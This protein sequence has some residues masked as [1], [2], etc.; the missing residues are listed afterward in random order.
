MAAGIVLSALFY[1]KSSID[2]KRNMRA[3]LRQKR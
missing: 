1:A 2:L 3:A